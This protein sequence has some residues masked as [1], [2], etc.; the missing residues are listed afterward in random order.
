[1]RK[2]KVVAMNTSQGH[3]TNDRNVESQGR[4]LEAETK[5]KEFFT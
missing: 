3:V 5:A 4:N 2:R 1:M